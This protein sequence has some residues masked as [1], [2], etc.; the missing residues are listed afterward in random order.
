MLEAIGKFQGELS[1]LFRDLMLGVAAFHVGLDAMQKMPNAS[2]CLD[3][4][5][6][7]SSEPIW[8]SEL[9]A[10]RETV[11]RGAIELFQ[12][13][14]IAIWHDL[15]NE[16]YFV[17]LR[18]HFDGVKS[19]PG[20]KVKKATFNFA[21]GVPLAEQVRNSLA[22]DFAF[23]KYKDKFDTVKKIIVLEGVSQHFEFIRKH[24]EIRNA[25][26]HHNG[27]MHQ[28]G[29]DLL[30][31]QKITVK[32]DGGDNVDVCLHGR[33][34]L[35]VIEVDVLKSRLFEVTSLMERYIEKNQA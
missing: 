24:V 28:G 27:T 26:Q 9:I 7:A 3:L 33:I 12:S 20:L 15:L 6:G 18:Q 8:I 2:M 5:G 14:A 22:E 30:G 10:N 32:D 4:S 11:R 19:W 21:S 29:L 1:S 31:L 16:I 13:K 35:S 34:M 17:A 25:F 23:V